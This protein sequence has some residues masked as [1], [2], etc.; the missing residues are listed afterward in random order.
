MGF[1]NYSND[2]DK[3]LPSKELLQKLTVISY[4]EHII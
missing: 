1:L 3:I 2:D 4:I